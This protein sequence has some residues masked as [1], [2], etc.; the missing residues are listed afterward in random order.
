M[1]KQFCT[2]VASGLIAS[3]ASAGATFGFISITNSN[4]GDAAIGEAQFMVEVKDAGAGSVEFLFT[5]AGP[6][7][8]SMVQLYWGDMGGVLSSLDS[9]STTT[10]EKSTPNYGVNYSDMSSASPGHLPGPNALS[11]NAD[12]S[13]QPNNK[14]GKS[15]N[16]VGAGEDVSIF[17]TTSNSYQ[18][19]VD[20]MS[21]GSLV[22]GIHAQAYDSGGSESFKTGGRPG[23]TP[24]PSPTAAFAGLAIL[25][26]VGLRRRRA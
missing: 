1:F 24:I 5:N 16:G 2:L 8:A 12:F 21:D 23:I 15:K 20:A 17:F 6:D 25:G 14:K 7:A 9:W 26:A 18:D 4:P 22:I 19:I 3:A 13:I 11:F 10:P